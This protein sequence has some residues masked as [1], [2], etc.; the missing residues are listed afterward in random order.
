M[1]ANERNKKVSETIAKYL[2]NPEDAAYGP[3]VD[4][5]NDVLV[6]C[7]VVSMPDDQFDTL[8]ENL[9]G[10]MQSI[11]MA[12]RCKVTDSLMLPK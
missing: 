10:A 5:I 4:L 6:M 9:D 11:Q 3:N 7:M 8:I 1:D 2:K 12:L